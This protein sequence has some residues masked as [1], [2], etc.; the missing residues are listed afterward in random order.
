MPA[1][2][3][4]PVSEWTMSH[5]KPPI[6]GTGQGWIRFGSRGWVCR[7]ER[8]AIQVPDFQ[9]DVMSDHPFGHSGVP[10]APFLPP[11]ANKPHGSAGAIGGSIPRGISSAF[12]PDCGA[13]PRDPARFVQFALQP[14]LASDGEDVFVRDIQGPAAKSVTAKMVDT[15]HLKAHCATRLRYLTGTMPNLAFP[16]VAPQETR[17]TKCHVLQATKPRQVRVRQK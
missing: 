1:L 15:S 7:D 17:S 8:T 2:K 10:F 4:T 5:T 13:M 9:G 14:L 3:R 16:A 6:A 11:L 12:G